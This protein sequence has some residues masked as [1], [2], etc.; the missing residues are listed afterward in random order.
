MSNKL[1][2]NCIKQKSSIISI[3]NCTNGI[4][5]DRLLRAS[6]NKTEQLYPRLNYIPWITVDDV[7]TH[8]IQNEAERKD[9]VKLVCDTYKVSYKLNKRK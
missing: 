3:L 9:L 4:E 7:N 5:G 8:V 1:L 6:G 2:K